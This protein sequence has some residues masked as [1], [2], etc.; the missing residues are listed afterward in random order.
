MIP[1]AAFKVGQSG[2]ITYP[3][4]RQKKRIITLKEAF[5]HGLNINSQSINMPESCIPSVPNIVL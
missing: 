3:E 4:I 5:F 1:I 2:N